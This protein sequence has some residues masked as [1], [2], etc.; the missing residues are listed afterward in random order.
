VLLARCLH[1]SL[2]NDWDCGAV[3]GLTVHVV[4]AQWKLQRK[5]SSSSVMGFTPCARVFIYPVPLPL[6]SPGEKPDDQL[7]KMEAMRLSTTDE[8]ST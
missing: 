2:I 8:V 4:R 7:S 6:F 1:S 3:V 5:E